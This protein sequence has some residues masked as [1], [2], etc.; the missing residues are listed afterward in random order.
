MRLEKKAEEELSKRKGLT[1]R[2]II[3]LIWLV[4]SFGI[5][6]F[7]LDTLEAEGQFTYLQ[8]RNSLSLP[9]QVPDW[10]IQGGIM[11]IFV[12]I[13]QFVLFMAFVWVSPEGRRRP[14]DPT[15]RSKHSDPFDDGIRG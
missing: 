8:L 1:I 11:L 4:I 6:Y 9:A 5:A 15:L 13:M 2:T 10:A 14:G 12:I 3:Q 7:V